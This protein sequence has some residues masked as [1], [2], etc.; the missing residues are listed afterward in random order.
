MTMPI[1]GSDTRMYAPRS[2]SNLGYTKDP[3][4][5]PHGIGDPEV[6]EQERDKREKQ[7]EG[8]QQTSDL[9]HLQIEV[10]QQNPEPQMPPAPEMPED[11]P[12]MDDDNENARGAEVSQMTGMPDV[13]NLSIGA[14]TG[15]KPGAGGQ[16]V[17]MGEPMDDAWSTLLK[18]E[19]EDMNEND[20]GL[21]A[22][23]THVMDS[24][25][26]PDELHPSALEV[27]M[28]AA[29]RF[30]GL[31][32]EDYFSETVDAWD[33]KEGHP[34]WQGLESFDPL[35]EWAGP[36]DSEG[37]RVDPVLEAE[38]RL[39][40]DPA[41]PTWN[42]E[43]G[44]T[45]SEPMDGAWSS[46][47]K[48]P[49]DPMLLARAKAGDPEA[50]Q[51]V[52]SLLREPAVHTPGIGSGYDP[53]NQSLGQR[54]R[55]AEPHS[56]EYADRMSDDLSTYHSTDD[57]ENQ[58]YFGDYR[59]DPLKSLSP[60]D[61]AWSSLMKSRLSAAPRG[62]AQSP[63]SQPQYKIQP[64]GADITTANTRR[65]KLYSRHLQPQ[66]H[67]GIDR[68][69]LSVHRTH[70]GIS[71]KQPLKLFPQKY[72]QQMGSMARRKWQGNIPSVASGHA[73]GPETTYSP[74]P[75]KVSASGGL[76][77]R[78]PTGPKMMGQTMGGPRPMMKSEDIAAI[79]DDLSAIQ[80]KMNYMHFAQMR[81]LMRQIK[82]TLA[83]KERRL[84]SEEIYDGHR[85]GETTE[86]QGATENLNAEDDP[87]NWGAPSRMFA[88]KGSGR[89]G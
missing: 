27:L 89:V 62:R 29:Q 45:M 49:I 15:T 1:T 16:L 64:G 39:D 72:G 19:E 76:A 57:V 56:G 69:P 37:K 79:K 71:T 85:D 24:G 59:H 68:A 3:E 20:R 63:W 77:I 47:M 87:K 84:K 50:I 40:P 53:E 26:S 36:S 17:N 74:K 31:V 35:E 23:A 83:N 22:A 12:V 11:E 4:D 75:P 43:T 25:L 65:A 8:E 86:P 54:D 21:M 14:A 88:A 58:M 28:R 60:L 73:M 44:F 6:M 38:A 70:L 67:R 7:K 18:E 80:K 48:A 41:K 33:E 34:D 2:E 32:P 10:P 9:P 5:N 13:G 61:D 81:R 78:S 55:F 42:E 51:T 66:K 52:H 82:D 46:L 30:E